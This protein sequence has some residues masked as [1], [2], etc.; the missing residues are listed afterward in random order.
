VK[1]TKNLIRLIS[2][3]ILPYLLGACTGYNRVELPEDQTLPFEEKAV[4]LHRA[5]DKFYLT[6][7]KITKE[8]IDANVYE[9]RF[10]PRLKKDMQLHIYVSP[11][12][13]IP[14][15][16]PARMSIP[17]TAVEKV[18]VYEVST[19]K[20]IFYNVAWAAPIAVGIIL[21]ANKGSC[22]FIYT[23]DGA[24]YEFAGEIY[25]GATHPPIE[26][27]DYLPLPALK[28]VGGEY[29]IKLANDV[30]EIQHTNLAE[31][32]VIDHPVGAEVLVDKYGVARTLS[33]LRP[34]AEATS[35][36]GEDVLGAV[37]AADGVCY[38]GPVPEEADADVD[39]IVMTFE[40]PPGATRAKLVI[41]AKNSIWL[42]YV[43]GEFLDLFGDAYADWFE[44]QKTASAEELRQW[45]FD[46]GIPLAVYVEEDGAWRLVDYYNLAGPMAAK[47]DVLAFGLP[48]G[49]SDE[50]KVKLEFGPLFW[51]ID[52]V[53][54]DCSADLPVQVHSVPIADAADESGGDVAALLRADDDLYY[55]QP[56]AGE[57]AL[58]SFAAPEP[59]EGSARSAVLHTKG[60]YEIIRN[61]QG[62]PDLKLLYSFKKP[63]RFV[64]FSKEIY[65]QYYEAMVSRED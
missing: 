40:R 1:I 15:P 60:H 56:E 24:G 25:S 26:R 64:E 33:D 12:F 8:E 29:K 59:V 27:H 55:V 4:I 10:A 34:P 7:C 9:G 62:K 21:L 50:V 41:Q 58:V 47:R 54:L 13:D 36:G 32:W 42:D 19:G 57:Y 22:P 35:A 48:A 51:E 6:D 30:R 43:Y 52:Y 39:G 61:P 18:E 14:E 49:S 23:F 53:A 2:V 37:A 16:L 38:V 45:S 11:E 46:Q 3:S 5:E 63:G 20:T 17:F 65:L 44:E 31:L 28:D